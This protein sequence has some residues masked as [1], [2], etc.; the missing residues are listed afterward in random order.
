MENIEIEIEKLD[1]LKIKGLNNEISN[2]KQSL[3]KIKSLV[4]N[5]QEAYLYKDVIINLTENI[6]F[7]FYN[8]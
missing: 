8:C 2:I 5:Q 7:L 1:E 4:K 3:L 6:L